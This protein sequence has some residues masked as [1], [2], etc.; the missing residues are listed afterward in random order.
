M[1][2][3]F[4]SELGSWLKNYY[5]YTLSA[6]IIIMSLFS[7]FSMGRPETC[8]MSSFCYFV[9]L[10]ILSGKEKWNDITLNEWISNVDLTFRAV[11]LGKISG[12]MVI[13]LI[14]IFFL[15]PLWIFMAKIWGIEWL[16]FV[17]ILFVF[18]P[19]M[20]TAACPD[21]NRRQFVAFKG[22]FE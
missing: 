2:P 22:K 18:L 1:I 12:I 14:H 10:G 4:V 5:R 20:A 21:I 6:M 11:I 19:G 9:I 7:V 17:E 3:V 8:L 15:F 13:G 16:S